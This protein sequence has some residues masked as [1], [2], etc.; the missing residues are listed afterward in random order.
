MTDRLPATDPADDLFGS[1]ERRIRF[2]IFREADTQ[3][4]TLVLAS[5]GG[6]IRCNTSSTIVRLGFSAL[7]AR[8]K[9]DRFGG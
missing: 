7:A 4:A 3:L 6:R 5:N 2:A 9:K 1:D 8:T